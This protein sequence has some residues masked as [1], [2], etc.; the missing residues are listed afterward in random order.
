M[1]GFVTAKL[2]PKD[3]KRGRSVSN[4]YSIH[5]HCAQS[6][7]TV[8]LFC[9]STKEELLRQSSDIKKNIKK[10]RKKDGF[11]T[12]RFFLIVPFTIRPDYF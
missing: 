10:K 6:A 2:R 11:E 4:N 12:E 8:D 1:H 3:S 7:V 5:I 9:H